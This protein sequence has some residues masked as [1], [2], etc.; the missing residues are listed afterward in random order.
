MLLS[1]Q[2]HFGA[3]TK[4]FMQLSLAVMEQL[5]KNNVGVGARPKLDRDEEG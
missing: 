4:V 1:L 3:R 5:V 2:G